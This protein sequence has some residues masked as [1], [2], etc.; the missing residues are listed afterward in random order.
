MEFIQSNIYAFTRKRNSEDFSKT[1]A[2]NARTNTGAPSRS[3][4]PVH[5]D[6]NIGKCRVFTEKKS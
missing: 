5:H 2:A 1:G 4:D 3:D 6:F